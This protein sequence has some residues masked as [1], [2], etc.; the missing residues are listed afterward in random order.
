MGELLDSS[1]VKLPVAFKNFIIYQFFV[2]QIE[3]L[4]LE[5]LGLVQF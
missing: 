5:C 1:K 4:L 3:S 2:S